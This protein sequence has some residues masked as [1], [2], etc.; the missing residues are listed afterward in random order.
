MEEITFYR[1]LSEVRSFLSK[2]MSDPIN[3]SPSKYL[4]NRD[5]TR[6]KLIKEL[7][8]RGVLTR[9]EKINVPKEGE[10]G[11]VKYS[12]T[13]KVRRKDFETKIKRIYIKFFE[14]N[15]PEK[16]SVNECEGGDGGGDIGGTSSFSVGA[17]TTRGDMGFD[18]PFGQVQRRP[19]Y[20]VQS[21]KGIKPE[22]ILGKTI[23]EM[24]KI[25][26]IYITEEQFSTIMEDGVTS[27]GTVGAMGDYTAQGLVLKTADGK[28]DPCAK[29]GHIKVKMV[30]DK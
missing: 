8:D 20:G 9:N 21:E 4:K 17:E 28:E 30:M 29:A 3:A 16:D 2:L 7:M 27:T 23:N 18:A 12:V 11:K 14:K 6:K 5:V 13:Y 24:K 22:N 15:V 10:N 1:F 25:R 26:R 19:I